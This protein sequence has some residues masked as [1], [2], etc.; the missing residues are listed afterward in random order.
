MWSARI[1]AFCLYLS[2]AIDSPY[3]FPC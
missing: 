1:G 2:C 3:S